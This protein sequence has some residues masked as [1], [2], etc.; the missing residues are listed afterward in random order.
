LRAIFPNSESLLRSGNT[1][2][3]RLQQQHNNAILVPQSATV[4]LQDKIFVFAVG[5]SNKVTKQALQVVGKSGT[6]YIVKDGVKTGDRIVFT[7]LDR[8]AEGTIIKPAPVKNT[9]QITMAAPSP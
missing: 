4:E 3:V 9:A 5:D 6:D 1:G 8:L 7:G 2:K